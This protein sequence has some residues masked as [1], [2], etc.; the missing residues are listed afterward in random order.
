MPTFIQKLKSPLCLFLCFALLLQL[1]PTETN[2][3]NFLEEIGKLFKK[4]RLPSEIKLTEKG[5]LKIE[6]LNW[7]LVRCLGGKQDINNDGIKEECANIFSTVTLGSSQVSLKDKSGKLKIAQPVLPEICELKI[8][9]PPEEESL[10]K[11]EKAALLK[12]CFDLSRLQ[13]AASRE[14]YFAKNIFN[15]TDPLSSCLFVR[16]CKSVCYLRFGDITLTIS[17]F[18]ILLAIGVPAGWILTLQKIANFAS[19]VIE[20]KNIIDQVKDLI[21]DGITALNDIFKTAANLSTLLSSIFKILDVLA[22]GGI[23]GFEPLLRRF[24]DN[25]FKFAQAKSE[26]F[27]LID[28]MA[29]ETFSL[30]E[31]IKNEEGGFIF[32]EDEAAEQKKES[33][34]T[35]VDNFV[36]S[37]QPIGKILLSLE[38]AGKEVADLVK[39]GASGD[40]SCPE[41]PLCTFNDFPSE[42]RLTCDSNGHCQLHCN[43]H[44]E[45][46]TDSDRCYYSYGYYPRTDCQI[47]VTT[48]PA[49]SCTLNCPSS[50]DCSFDYQPLGIYDLSEFCPF[51][52][53]VNEVLRTGTKMFCPAECSLSCLEPVQESQWFEKFKDFYTQLVNLEKLNLTKKAEK[54][55]NGEKIDDVFKQFKKVTASQESLLSEID[56][57]P[58]KPGEPSKHLYW[59]SFSSQFTANTWAEAQDRAASTCRYN[60]DLGYLNWDAKINLIKNVDFSAIRDVFN[61]ALQKLKEDQDLQSPRTTNKSQKISNKLNEFFYNTLIINFQINQIKAQLDTLSSQFPAAAEKINALKEALSNLQSRFSEISNRWFET[62]MANLSQYICA[63]K[64]IEIKAGEIKEI[65]TNAEQIRLEIIDALATSS[66]PAVLTSVQEKIT[67]LTSSTDT[68]LKGLAELKTRPLE[69]TCQF[70]QAVEKLDETIEALKEVEGEV[71]KINPSL[72]ITALQIKQNTDGSFEFSDSSIKDFDDFIDSATQNPLSYL[73]ETFRQIK[74]LLAEGGT[75]VDGLDYLINN[76]LFSDDAKGNANQLKKKKQWLFETIF[77]KEEI[78][79]ACR[80]LNLIFQSSPSEIE[81]IC[82]NNDFSLLSDTDLQKTCQQTPP[83]KMSE[84]LTN[85]CNEFYS[86]KSLQSLCFRFELLQKA[87]QNKCPSNSKTCQDKRNSL[88]KL[89]DYCSTW[90]GTIPDLTKD[91]DPQTEGFQNPLLDEA[92]NVC[93]TS[94]NDIQTPLEEVMSVF[95]I[96]LGIESWT[97]FFGGIKTSH[98]DIKR[99]YQNA[100]DIIKNIKKLFENEETKFNNVSSGISIGPPKCVPAPASGWQGKTSARGGPVCPDISKLFSTM[101]SEFSIIR[102]SLKHLDMVRRRKE[103]LEVDAGSIHAS[104]IARYPVRYH[105]ANEVYHLAEEVKSRAQNLWAIATA[106]NFAAENCTCGKSFC[107]F[108]LCVSGVPLTLSPLS[109]P[110]CFLTYLLRPILLKQVEVLENFLEKEK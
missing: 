37:F 94:A 15:N 64:D 68:F 90:Q 53:S 22:E 31:Q 72:E 17:V 75:L 7:T 74:A 107:K 33:L 80:E 13:I 42:C 101:E 38:N 98:M 50:A 95:S 91:E 49:F 39:K 83:D 60:F 56:K 23:R 110:Y 11:E 85:Q 67:I 16:N 32:K 27:S 48:S 55:L 46:T 105:L 99:V 3:F 1:F 106:I 20:I 40:L 82:Q 61:S 5:D 30:K 84:E 21:R 36:A 2:A 96:L 79:Q 57:L 51:L 44:K 76:P 14:A 65:L 6:G 35:L 26:A 89:F 25:L 29:Q 8:P 59:A 58:F 87:L 34:R 19:K 104:I 108:P 18:D 24:S 62:E 73:D 70:A 71:S 81:T 52:R 97:G 9:S 10:S 86:Q 93:L 77:G 54:F 41:T 69:E 78:R 109:D 92:K 45:T 66:P 12:A 43:P 47:S 88:A 4:V 103:W 63:L 100:S 28:E 102:N